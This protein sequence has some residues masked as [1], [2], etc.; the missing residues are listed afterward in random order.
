M[1]PLQPR[2]AELTT[3]LLDDLARHAPPADLHQALAMPLP[4]QVICELLGVPYA[5][6]DE[7]RAWSEAVGDVRDRARSET[8]LTELFSYSQRLASPQARAARGRRHLPAVRRRS[9]RRRDHGALDEP[10][11]RGP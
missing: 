1:R 6:R 10:A 9:R 5:D 11:V 3:T 4:I 7:F 8:G 2:M